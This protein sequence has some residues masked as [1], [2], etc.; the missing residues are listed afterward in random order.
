M[1]IVTVSGSLEG[2]YPYEPLPDISGTS[3]TPSLS[4]L[5]DFDLF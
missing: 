5:S 2:S 3:V 4:P 1:M